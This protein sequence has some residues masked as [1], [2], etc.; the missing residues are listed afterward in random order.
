MAVMAQSAS[1]QT[2]ERRIANAKGTVAFEYTTRRAVCGNGSSIEISD[3][4]SAG[5][6]TRSRR[7]GWIRL[8]VRSLLEALTRSV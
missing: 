2:L 4:T 5:W 3:D 7:S 6:T 8:C 1:A